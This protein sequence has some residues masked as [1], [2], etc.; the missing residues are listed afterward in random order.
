MRTVQTVHAADKKVGMSVREL[1]TAL[2]NA[3]AQTTPTVT[4]S[5]SGKIRSITLETE[6]PDE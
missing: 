4:T 5:W 1:R 2:H 3:D 6:T